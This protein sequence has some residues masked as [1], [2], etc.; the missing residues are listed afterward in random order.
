MTQLSILWLPIL[1]VAVLAAVGAAPAALLGARF[2]ADARAA[3]AAPAGAAVIACVS[4]LVMLGI[5]VRGLLIATVGASIAATVVLHETLRPSLR[6][7]ALPAVAALV[8]L[9]VVAAPSVGRGDWNAAAVDNTD[10]YLW[11]S[12]AK[13]FLDGPPPG[14]ASEFPDRI[15]YERIDE[16]HWQV[17]LPVGV[18]GVA[19]LARADPAAVYG[20]FSAVVAVLLALVVYGCGRACLGWRRS[21]AAAAAVIVTANAFMLYSSFNGWQAQIAL[22]TFGTLL[23]FTLR[24]ALDADALGRE[25]LLAGG[26]AAAGIATYGV[27]FAP[28][29]LLAAAVTASVLA[30]RSRARPR[31]LKT[32]GGCAAAAVVIGALPLLQTVRSLP[33]FFAQSD[34]L[35]W[36]SYA[37]GLPAEALGLI[38]RIGTAHRPPAF[39]WS[40]IAFAI[41]A[42]LFA[43]GFWRARSS[44]QRRG[45]VLLATGTLA[46]GVIALLQLPNANPYFS[47]KFVGYTAPILTMVALN[48]LVGDQRLRRLRVAVAAAAASCFAVSVVI[49]VAV[50]LQHVSSTETLGTIRDHLDALPAHS[51]VAVSIDDEWQQSW[52]V[53]YLRDH[54]LHVEDPNI[55]LTGFG[56][57]RRTF[58]N[59]PAQYALE[60]RRSR[61]TAIWHG[62]GLVL[63]K[64]ALAGGAPLR[65]LTLR[66]VLRHPWPRDTRRAIE[67]AR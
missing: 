18:A 48:G 26:A 4:V 49:V 11:V 27:L 57:R 59:R 29:A 25:Q 51:R 46:L 23:V 1:T 24:M 38:P 63:H 39:G 34:S 17:A 30:T 14:P 16:L 40:V 54:P 47:M 2:P 50:D 12:Q 62:D 67:T 20:A 15:A 13:A 33:R 19:M 56:L 60:A 66:S 21:V 65:A 31:T 5:P 43:F 3:L 6:S 28:F 41:A 8:A 58:A 10:P 35:T 7:A 52:A 44:E 22:T 37:H 53:Y 61:S 32:V 64:I 45:D 42:A 9:A 55:F 36:S